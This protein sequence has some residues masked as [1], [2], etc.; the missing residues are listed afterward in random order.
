MLAFDESPLCYTEALPAVLDFPKSVA[1]T[2]SDCWFQQQ[3]LSGIMSGN[4][5]DLLPDIITNPIQCKTFS[6]Q[7][8]VVLI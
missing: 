3:W 2:N 7:V 6:F 1:A 4:F 8:S 5:F